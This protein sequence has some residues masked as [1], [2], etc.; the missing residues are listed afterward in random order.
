MINNMT[1]LNIRNIKPH[2]TQKYNN[3][4]ILYK[5]KHI[6]KQIKQNKKILLK[7][8]KNNQ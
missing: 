4:K 2:N 1:K 5:I 6:N 8:M 3:N 7:E